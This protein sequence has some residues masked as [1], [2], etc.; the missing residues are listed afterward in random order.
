M[1]MCIYIYIYIY[2]YVC[3]YV[4]VCMYLYTYMYVHLEVGGTSR[5]SYARTA[6]CTCIRTHARVQR[7]IHVDVGAVTSM[8]P[9]RIYR[10]VYI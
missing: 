10:Y 1:Y 3:V 8:D 9:D 2:I 7:Q 4:C 5:L 6:V